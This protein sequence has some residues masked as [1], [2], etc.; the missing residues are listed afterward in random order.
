[1]GNKI[2]KKAKYLAKYL[3]FYFAN[4]VWALHKQIN[5]IV[6][7]SLLRQFGRKNHWN[8][9]DVHQIKTMLNQKK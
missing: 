4:V 8:V 9:V 5:T 6:Q 2:S 3:A 7:C 1:M